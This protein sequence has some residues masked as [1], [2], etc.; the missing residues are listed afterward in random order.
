MEQTE[1]GPRGGRQRRSKCREDVVAPER[2]LSTLAAQG[3]VCREAR[4]MISSRAMRHAT[5]P[6]GGFASGTAPSTA[7]GLDGEGELSTSGP[8]LNEHRLY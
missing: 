3:D 5:S 8:H 2:G 7:P 6:H 4:V 1:P